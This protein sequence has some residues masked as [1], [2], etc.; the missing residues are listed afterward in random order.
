MGA[1]LGAGIAF[2]TAFAVFGMRRVLELPGTG[3][4]GVL[5]WI[6]PAAI[7]VPGTYLWQRHYRRKFGD[8]GKESKAEQQVIPQSTQAL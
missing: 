4:L 7:G 5:P 1:T 6:L 8:L 2:H 3:L